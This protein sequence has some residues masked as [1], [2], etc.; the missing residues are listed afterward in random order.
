VCEVH[1][2][3]VGYGDASL[4]LQ[5]KP[6][7]R[8]F[9][10]LIDCGGETIGDDPAG[11]RVTAWEYL[12]KLGIDKID[13]VLLTHLHLDHSGGILNIARNFAV[14]ELWTNYVPNKA[15]WDEKIKIDEELASGPINLLKSLQL[16]CQ[17]LKILS[18]GG[19]RIREITSEFF[20][21]GPLGNGRILMGNAALQNRQSKILDHIF[22]QK[23]ENALLCELDGFI[24]NTSLRT[25]LHL[26]HSVFLFAG[27]IYASEWGKEQIDPAD[28]VKIP[29]HG[30][31][32]CMS[33]VI[34][35]KLSAKYAI[36]S[37]SDTRTDCPSPKI[38]EMLQ[39]AGSRVLFTDAVK[40]L[41][42]PGDPKHSAIV[43]H[44]EGG[45]LHPEFCI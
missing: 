25:Q 13:I 29:H 24:N 35:K 22:A 41:D 18:A 6:D 17:A 9:C 42:G 5:K 12:K 11:L 16:Y 21:K 28:V 39:N 27:D 30:H 23:A 45:G 2:I 4:I 19:T 1:F 44:P 32:D 38:L 14:S 37:V 20:F 26:K 43:F 34:A 31:T 15:Y 33:S 36:V 10:M 7:G 40:Q 3:N 8:Q